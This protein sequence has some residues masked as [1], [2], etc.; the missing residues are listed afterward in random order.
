MCRIQTETWTLLD[1][2]R[3]KMIS[4]HSAIRLYEVP[5]TSPGDVLF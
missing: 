3:S 4:C 1:E 2:V 5:N